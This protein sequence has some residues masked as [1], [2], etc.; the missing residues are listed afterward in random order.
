MGIRRLTVLLGIAVSVL[1]SGLQCQQKKGSYMQIER[2]VFGKLPDGRSADLFT[3][4]NAQGAQVKITNYGGIV[5]SVR[6]P[7]R[8]GRLGDVVLGFDDLEGYLT[9]S[10][11]F[12]CIVGRYANR[13]AGG[14]FELDGQSF[15]LARNDGPN[16]LHGGETG[17]D[18]KLWKCEEIREQDAVGIRL[19]NTSPDGEEGY[20]GRLETAV[21]Y[22][23]TNDNAL[24]ITYEAVTDKKTVVNLT[25][26]SY[27]NLA[28]GG[29][30]L[31]HLLMINSERFT[32]VDNTLIP[33][34][35]R[36]PVEGTPMDFRERV[37]IGARIE[38]EYVQLHFGPGG[39]DH[40][41]V[42]NRAGG[43]LC[44]AARVWEPVTG[45]ILAVETTQPGIQFYSGNFLDGSIT[46][47]SGEVYQKHAGFCLE[48][49]HF[50]DSPNQPVFPSVTLEPGE[51]YKQVTVYRFS[52]EK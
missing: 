21:T 18:K 33:S 51:Q 28:G 32:P 19:T 26:H 31:D 6:V 52:V 14:T 2:T 45:R 3:L 34:G 22:R 17:F 40:N 36:L 23:W 47:K 11:Y 24:R 5:V 35:E 16:H 25:N 50:P 49:Q 37:A 20:P 13:I 44:L 42:L 7:D 8:D 46:G 29:D 30:I 15:T 9:E 41:W 38:D 1:I 39:Y 43:D 4:T 12:G 10:P 48:T 27:F